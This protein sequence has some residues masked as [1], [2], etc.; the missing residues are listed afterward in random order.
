MQTYNTYLNEVL[1]NYKREGK[2]K[3]HSALAHKYNIGAIT[4]T[5]FFKWELHKLDFIPRELS[6]KIREETLLKIRAKKPEIPQATPFE[7]FL[8][9]EQ[10]LRFEEPYERPSLEE[11]FGTLRNYI[12]DLLSMASDELPFFDNPYA[13]LNNVLSQLEIKVANQFFGNVEDKQLGVIAREMQPNIIHALLS[14]ILDNKG[15]QFK[16]DFNAQGAYSEENE[17]I[18]LILHKYGFLN[19]CSRFQIDS[20]KGLLYFFVVFKDAPN[21]YV[22]IGDNIEYAI[23]N[24]TTTRQFSSFRDIFNGI[25]SFGGLG[26]RTAL[27]QVISNLN[28]AKEIAIEMQNDLKK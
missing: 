1:A 24:N 11:V 12:N 21:I 9:E 8:I 23:T 16:L 20:H 15:E 4:I 25:G 2:L 18:S 5:D 28:K 17:T 13:T 7:E 19:D 14:M 22:S 6:D 10:K 27:S 3:N 26:T